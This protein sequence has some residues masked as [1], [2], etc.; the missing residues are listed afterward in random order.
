MKILVINCGSSTL[1]FQIFN[2]ETETPL[3]KG[4]VEKIGQQAGWIRF[5]VKDRD[6]KNIDQQFKDHKDA[7]A[8]MIKVLTDPEI[9]CLKN[10]DEIYAVGHRV[11]HGGSK[12]SDSIVID[13]D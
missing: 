3:I 2:M 7:F 12:Y 4:A 9:G 8:L 6:V 13:G 1:K 11:V 5:R 10:L